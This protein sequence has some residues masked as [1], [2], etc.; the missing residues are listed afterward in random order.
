M[1]SRSRVFPADER[2]QANLFLLVGLTL[3]LLALTLL[4][5]RLGDANQWRSRVQTAADSAA[6]AAV[7]VARDN[8][9]EM[10]AR[11]Q[12]PVSP[13]YEP[14]L[15]RTTAERYAQ[16]NGAV[17]ESIRASD[18]TMGQIGNYVR[19]EVSGANCRQELQEDRGREWSDLVCPPEEEREDEEGLVSVGNASAIAEMVIPNCDYVFG[20]EYQIVGVECEGQVIQSVQHARQV[21]EIRLV[22]EEGQYLYKPLG[23][24]DQP[25][26][27]SP[28]PSQ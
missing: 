17:L 23:T 2:G 28:S 13:L 25:S 16:K 12:I 15:G 26:E 3:S 7:T 4:F 6:L 5:I 14:A 8:A 21:I 24:S 22:S 1:K 18:D 11:N 10:L 27:P 20:V 19:V 9:A